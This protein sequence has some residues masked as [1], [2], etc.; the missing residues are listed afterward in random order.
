M[1]NLEGN[2]IKCY[3]IFFNYQNTKTQ[4]IQHVQTKNIC[5]SIA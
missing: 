2:I 3:A 5:I 4:V 1:L